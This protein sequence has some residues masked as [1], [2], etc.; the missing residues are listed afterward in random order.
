MPRKEKNKKLKQKL[1]PRQKQKQ[2][3][4][5][6]IN[7]HID[8]SKKTNPRQPGQQQ[9]P[10]KPPPYTGPNIV[11]TPSPIIQQP[12]QQIPIQ[13]INPNLFDTNFNNISQ[14]FDNLE[15]NLSSF[16]SN[17][18]YEELTN[19]ITTRLN[20]LDKNVPLFNNFK[21]NITTRLNNLNSNINSLRESSFPSDYQT[22]KM[23]YTS[24]SSS[25]NSPEPQLTKKVSF[26]ESPQSRDDFNTPIRYANSS[27]TEKASLPF[28]SPKR[29]SLSL[30]NPDYE[31]SQIESKND[32]ETPKLET[33]NEAFIENFQNQ[34]LAYDTSNINEKEKEQD[35]KKIKSIEEQ[36]KILTSR[37]F[38][39]NDVIHPMTGEQYSNYSNMKRALKG[40]IENKN[41]EHTEEQIKE[42]KEY[43]KQYDEID[44]QRKKEKTTKAREVKQE[45]KLENSAVKHYEKRLK[46]KTLDKIYSL[47]EDM[48]AKEE[49]ADDHYKTKIKKKVFEALDYNK[50][51]EQL[52]KNKG[53]TFK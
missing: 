14:R 13:P 47:K 5:Q 3:Q 28:T 30:K 29:L 51:D 11:Y 2:K 21:D 19:D 7:I 20:N 34:Q 42:A 10:P 26:A 23:Y 16:S 4:S 44:E 27:R 12:N 36:R 1:K 15:R 40:Y 45:I 49:A 9:Q 50:L 37:E 32:F 33:Q 22:P 6:N 39:Y 41:K 43:L 31:T 25:D 46:K 18:H 17:P 48:R 35:D 52:N 8:Q 38:K 53:R 24:E